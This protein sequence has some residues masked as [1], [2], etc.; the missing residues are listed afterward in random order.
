MKTRI[1]LLLPVALLALSQTA[2]ACAVCMGGDDSTVAGAMNAAIFSLLGVVGTVGAGFFGFVIYLS[3]R[4]K[5]P[6]PD[7][8]DLT[9]E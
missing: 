7:Y 3:R 8:H 1:F 5:S 4:A 9:E 6:L 2:G